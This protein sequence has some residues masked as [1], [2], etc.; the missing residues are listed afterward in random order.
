LEVKQTKQ[1]QPFQSTQ[2]VEAAI[3]HNSMLSW[4]VKNNTKIPPNRSPESAYAPPNT[5]KNSTAECGTTYSHAVEALVGFEFSPTQFPQPYVIHSWQNELRDENQS[6][7]EH[8]LSACP[9][10]KLHGH[11]P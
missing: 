7:A 9:G 5:P 2:Q 4:Q 1:M 3:P 6:N 10:L 11:T 8:G